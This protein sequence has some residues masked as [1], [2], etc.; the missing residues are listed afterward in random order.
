MVPMLASTLLFALMD[1]CVKELDRFGCAD[2]T[3]YRCLISCAVVIPLLRARKIPLL[4]HRRW[5]LTSRG[6]TGAASLLL[7]FATLQVLPMPIAVTMQ[8]LSP[9]FTTLISAL[10]LR[11]APTRL[12]WTTVFLAFIGVGLIQ[13]PEQGGSLIYVALGGLGA[14]LAA[15]SYATIRAIGD[16]DSP[17]VIVLFL[18]MAGGAVT[19]PWFVAGSHLPSPR[20]A[21]LI[22][23][24][25]LSA[26]GA[27]C[28]MTLAF[29]KQKAP[30]VANLTCLNLVWAMLA[31]HWL[32]NEPLSPNALAGIALITGCALSAG[33]AARWTGAEPRLSSRGAASAQRPAPDRPSRL[34]KEQQ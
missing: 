33:S 22:A 1:C 23:L 32:W 18:G 16:A 30:A 34:I 12:Q 26:L 15:V 10:V 21:V 19:L 6:L 27:Q 5:L 29:Q 3:F 4:G 8:Y 14:L 11:E 9:I 17:L 20:E 24:M 2:L 7:F 25:G 28:C 13:G 31:N